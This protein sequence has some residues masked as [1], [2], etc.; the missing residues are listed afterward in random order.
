MK[1]LLAL[2]LSIITLCALLSSCGA[3]DQSWR[4]QTDNKGLIYWY[5]DDDTYTLTGAST[6]LSGEISINT[7]NG[8]PVVRIDEAFRGNTSITSVFIGEN[9]D[10]IASHAFYD[11]S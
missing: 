11:C 9:V 10:F 7:F 1:K 6:S 5:N 4:R 8:L 3:E 2:L